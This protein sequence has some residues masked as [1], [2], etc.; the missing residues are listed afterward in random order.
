M[1][2]KSKF[3]FKD[4]LQNLDKNN[5]PKIHYEN[6]EI[7]PKDVFVNGISYILNREK[8]TASINKIYSTSDELIIPR[9]ITY[10]RKNYIIS[11]FN[12]SVI[13]LHYIKHIDFED[14]SE[15]PEIGVN[16]FANTNLTTISIPKSVKKI[17][18]DA[19][20]K[21]IN[22][23]K[24]LFHKGSQLKTI[25]KNAFYSS[26]IKSISIPSSV[27]ELKE[28][29]CYGTWLLDDVKIMPNNKFFT[30]YDQNLVIGKSDINNNVY[31]IL[32]FAPRNITELK[33]PSFIQK[34]DSFAFSFS[35][36][37]K[38]GFS[39]KVK[40]IKKGAFSNCN[41]LQKVFIPENSE[42]EKI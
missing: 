29:W 30:N 10:K 27:E 17:C 23:Q 18:Q 35:T 4:I 37:K 12:E 2:V 8:Q 32:V 36:L 16:A 41:D 11:N 40:I 33:I 7:Y 31:D 14:D 25:E 42:L 39:Q 1:K 26:P 3:N 22:I 24:V 38:I 34:I 6:Y 28:G 15:I 20:F 5:K 9:S 19:F 13:G 21:C